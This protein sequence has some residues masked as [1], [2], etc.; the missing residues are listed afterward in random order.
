MTRPAWGRVREVFEE[1][2]AR[3]HAEREAFLDAACA[4]N[5]SLRDEV[6]S[7]RS[8]GRTDA[9]LAHARS[10]DEREEPV[11]AERRHEERQPG[12]CG[13][14]PRL[15][16]AVGNLSFDDGLERLDTR[17]RLARIDRPDLA[18]HG[19]RERRR[20]RCRANRERARAEYANLLQLRRRQVDRASRVG[21][22]EP[23]ALDVADDA[24][25]GH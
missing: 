5:T 18:L 4:G 16:L 17:D 22:V 14:E 19:C 20:I 15:H 8:H 1:A 6:A 7:L 13:E 3:E 23:F 10:D 9:E 12:E 11:D 2:L 21:D 25:N 24:N